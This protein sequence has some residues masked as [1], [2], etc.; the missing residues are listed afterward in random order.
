MVIKVPYTGP[1]NRNNGQ[2][3]SGD[4]KL[5]RR[6]NNVSTED[7]FAHNLALMLHEHG[8]R[9]NFTLMFETPQTALL[10]RLVRISLTALFATAI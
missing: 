9:V 3:L 6:Y 5:D 2:L 4:K 8:Y 7:A 1:V 10:C